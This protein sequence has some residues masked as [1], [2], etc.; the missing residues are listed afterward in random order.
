MKNTPLVR[1]ELFDMKKQYSTGM[2]ILE[3]VLAIG[4]FA[5]FATPAIGVILQGFDS[6]RLAAEQT[7]ATQ[8]AAEGIEAVRSIKNQDFSSVVN[9]AATG[10]IRN[11][12][13]VW[14]FSGTNNTFSNQKTYTRVIGI[15]DV[16]RDAIGNIVSSGGTV[17]PLSKKVTST[18]TWSF[19]PGRLQTMTFVNYLSDWRRQLPVQR[20]G[21]LVY[22]NGGLTTD[23]MEYKVLD[24]Y[25]VW[26][27]AS[28][29]ADI[30]GGTT[31]RRL[32]AIRVYSSPAR[33][34]K[35]AISR[36]HNGSTQYIY[37]QV[38]NGTT[39]G[40][41][42]L[43]A[44]WNAN[45]FLDV[46]NFDGAYLANGDFMV[47][48]SNNTTTPQYATW[49]GASWTLRGATRNVGGIPTFIVAKRRPATSEVM[50]A[51]FDQS[52]DTNTE[53]FNIGVNGT[54]ELADWTL[55]TEH[56][57]AA[58]NNSRELVDFAWS[59]NTPT[60][61]ALV[62]SNATNDTRMNIRIFNSS[63]AGSWGSTAEAPVQGRLVAVSVEGRN[64]AD[65]F[66]ACATDTGED[67]RCYESNFTPAWTTPTNPIIELTT[68][69]GNQRS[70]Q[71]AYEAISGATAIVVYSDQSNIPKLKRYNP[72]TNTWDADAAQIA[73]GTMGAAVKTVRM[74]AQND[75]DDVMILIGDNNIDFYTAIWNGEVNV[76]YTAPV[77]PSGKG[78][79]VQGTNGS[80]VTDMWY[81]FEWDRH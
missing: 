47:V 31:N 67:I 11:G 80:A 12:S 39:W 50:V 41:V 15:A 24:E 77:Y 56:T 48:Y 14:A 42:Q 2:S 59:P 44:N 70:Y 79:T 36:H 46:R 55:H 66:V 26:S 51:V 18:V 9:T 68:D 22:G 49:N 65:E 40:N 35:I 58:P 34:E 20:R 21:V 75:S 6:N 23:A 19:S 62:Y 69:T 54:Y 53:Y 7:I 64:G 72:A 71:V 30:D 74:A 8:F 32:R 5:I 10:V 33:N 73:L 28:S 57:A 13:N 63:G 3:V 1:G 43:L 45:T 25:G 81:D 76:P 17:D 27:A 16:Q 37:A 52:S 29:M 38:F 78:L 60:R 4:I 61:G